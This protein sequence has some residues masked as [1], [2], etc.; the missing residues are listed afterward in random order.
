M[1]PR[2]E[3]LIY[4]A[5]PAILGAAGIVFLKRAGKHFSSFAPDSIISGF[6]K[7]F[8]SIDIWVGLTLYLLAFA[9]LMV[10]ISRVEVSRFYPIAVGLNIVFVTLGG[11]VLLQE[12]LSLTKLFGILLVTAGVYFVSI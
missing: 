2:V 11:L 12:G 4:G 5:V 1:N 9:W 7:A 6:Q 8:L 10:V 3:L